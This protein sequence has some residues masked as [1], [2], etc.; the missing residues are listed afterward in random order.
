MNSVSLIYMNSFPD[1]YINKASIIEEV[2]VQ[3]EANEVENIHVLRTGVCKRAI[4]SLPDECTHHV[5][6]ACMCMEQCKS[7]M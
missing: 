5:H 6:D 1:V 4:F 2:L 7:Y 3:V